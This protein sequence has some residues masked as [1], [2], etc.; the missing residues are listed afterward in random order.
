MPELW[1]GHE[2]TITDCS[3]GRYDQT[4]RCGHYDRLE[5]LDAFAD[6]G[7]KTLRYP[8][9]W[10]QVSPD[11]PQARD[12]D[13]TDRRLKRLRDLKI[14]VIAGLVHHGAGPA[15]TNLLDPWFAEGLAEHALAAAQRYPWIEA[16][17]PV[18][19]PLTTARFSCL[20]GHWRPFGRDERLFWTA[21]FNQLDGVKLS[22][23]AARRVNPAARL[24]QTED[25]G[26]THATA[27]LV[28]QAEH[29]NA[30]RW[31][32][33][34]L[35]TGRVDRTHPLFD[36]VDRLGLGDRM[37]RFAD[38]PCPPDVIGVNHYLTSDRLL[39]HR[40]DRYPAD[41]HG[42]NGRVAYAD[43]EAVRAL[44]PGPALMEGALREACA[45]YGLPVALT[46]V[47]NACTREE[48]MRW[49]NE[50]WTAAARLEAEGRP[51]KAVTVWSLLGA[52]DWNSLMTRWDG[53]YESGAFDLR[54]GSPRPTALADMVRRLTSGDPAPALATTP[55]WWRRDVRMTFAPAEL[56]AGEPAMSRVEFPAASVR[57]L[58]ITG[59][60]GTLGRAFARACQRRGLDYVLTDRARLPLEDSD[61]MAR[62]LEAVA[63]W[64]VINAAGYVRVDDA[65]TDEA[66]CMRGNRDGAVRLAGV[67]AEWNLP[68]LTFS[69]DLV[70]DGAAARPYLE[71][72]VP[73]PINAYG[74]S[75]ALA[76][77]G[78]LAA[79]GRALIARTAAFFSASDPW[80]FA[81][82]VEADLRSGR[83][84][85][86]AED[87]EISPTY[88][89]DLVD[90]ALDLLIDGETGVWHL[91]S[92]GR[93][94]WAEFGR[95]IA[96]SRGLDPHLIVGCPAQTLNWRAR[97]PAMS[98]LASSRGQLL[99]PLDEALSRYARA[100]AE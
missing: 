47:H 52:Y 36:H 37:L 77:K 88:V 6:L 100:M 55:G 96:R 74:R 75:K 63:P 41:R 66:G 13:W 34:D 7:I 81:R 83:S 89:P 78:V 43:V 90:A 2:C 60:T 92:G 46:E 69:S 40:L 4:R 87:V 64:A 49:L 53:S 95:M 38:A 50:A 19:E 98:A 32:T 21:L 27:P 28:A 76:E 45:R 44:T 14:T 85:L 70:F 3:A 54:G 29:D 33:W 18:N 51:V 10:E 61:Q 80:N 5:D 99:A 8:L 93:A 58:L 20:Y 25:L 56:V 57:P 86:A 67:C 24:I 48:Q 17:T 42:G 71:D 39:D 12:W 22:M 15:Y 9:L 65:E 31:M 82:A 26:R 72:D 16:W 30:R 59:A 35:L 91:A 68:L 79:G 97:R 94:S 73:A 11:Q 84:V 62:T 1:G 23:A